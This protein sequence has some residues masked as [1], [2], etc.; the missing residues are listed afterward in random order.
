MVHQKKSRWYCSFRTQANIVSSEDSGA[1]LYIKVTYVIFSNSLNIACTLTVS[2]SLPQLSNQQWQDTVSRAGPVLQDVP[3]HCWI[4]CLLAVHCPAVGCQW[5]AKFLDFLRIDS[6][7]YQPAD[8]ARKQNCACAL[9]GSWWNLRRVAYN[10]PVVVAPSSGGSQ[11]WV[12]KSRVHEFKR[13]CWKTGAWELAVVKQEKSRWYCS[14]RTR[15]NIV[16][17]EGSRA[18]L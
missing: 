8:S 1:V 7:A 11:Q 4:E 14:F 15:A 12:Q 6:K 13:H 17:S 5:R 10:P 9:H 16:N 3:H 18:V 2:V